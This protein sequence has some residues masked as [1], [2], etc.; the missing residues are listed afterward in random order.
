M[1]EVAL[2]MKP[3]RKMGW[4]CNLQIIGM[5]RLTG[6]KDSGSYRATWTR[7]GTGNDI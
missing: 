2:E 1:E 4:V 6:K 5:E 3:S 7:S